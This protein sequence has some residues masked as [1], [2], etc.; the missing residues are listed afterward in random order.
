M[1]PAELGKRL[2]KISAILRKKIGT[3]WILDYISS[4]EFC[5]KAFSI[6]YSFKK[7]NWHFELHFLSKVE[8]STG[9]LKKLLLFLQ[10]LAYF[11]FEITFSQLSFATRHIWERNV[12]RSGQLP[13]Y[14]NRS[15]RQQQI[16]QQ[17]SKFKENWTLCKI[18]Q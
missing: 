15:G 13:T 2:L 6:R 11:R 17:I 4:V 7:E 1:S 16:L 5:D 18:L 9:L 12:G 10:K 8:F 14:C 3:F